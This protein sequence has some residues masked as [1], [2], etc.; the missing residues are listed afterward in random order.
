MR[1]VIRCCAIVLLAGLFSGELSAAENPFSGKKYLIIH[2]DDAGMS[3]SVNLATIESMEKGI[4]SSCSIMVPCPW[5]PEFADYARNHPEKDYGLHLT[6]NSEWK[7]YKWRPVAPLS[8]VPSLVD[9]EGYLW[10]DVPEVALNAKAAEVE[11]ELRAQI[12]RAKQ[13]RIPVTH[14]DTHMGTLF[15]RSDIVDVYV[16]LGIE[17]QLPILYPRNLDAKTLALLPHMKE[18]G[19]EFIRLLEHEKFPLLDG[20]LRFNDGNDHESRKASYLRDM[21]DLQ[22]GLNQIIIHC[23][24]GN[25]ELKA[26]TGTAMKRDSDR[27]V[28]T[29]P[30]MIAEIRRLGIEVI[31]WKQAWEMVHS[32]K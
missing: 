16:R 12:E 28:F 22:P 32:V 8:Q 20:L 21:Q 18:R 26:I 23:G 6:M 31:T 30:E 27:R 15:S 3:H 17:Y 14:L 25:D 11:I 29:D 7:H 13:F 9:K 2:A 1:F 4:V 19:P 10:P 5:F 24:I